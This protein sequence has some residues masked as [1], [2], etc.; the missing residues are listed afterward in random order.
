M[1]LELVA[2][3]S[4]ESLQ[5]FSLSF[6][7]CLVQNWTLGYMDW[8]SWVGGGM[9][10]RGS[11]A[12]EGVILLRCQFDLLAS[13]VSAC[14]AMSILCACTRSLCVNLLQSQIILGDVV[15]DSLSTYFKR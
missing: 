3:K 1:R 8:S 11:R 6:H 2:P 15:V 5:L 4:D 12:G 13:T 10:C 14:V 9:V 7:S